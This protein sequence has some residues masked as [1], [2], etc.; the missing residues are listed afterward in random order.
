[1]SE[2]SHVGMGYDL[3]PVCGKKHGESVLLDKRLQNTLERETFTGWNLCP[4]HQKLFEQGFLALVAVEENPTGDNP[5]VTAK[6]TGV[7]MHIKREVADDIFNIN[8]PPNIPMTWVEPEVIDKINQMM[9]E[10]GVEVH[11]VS[12]KEDG[13]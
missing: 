2:K 3:C 7:V 8:L 13:T 11:N 9:Q 10:Q 5:L 12:P 1:M 6:R 4:E